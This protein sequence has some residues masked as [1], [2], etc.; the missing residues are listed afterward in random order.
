MNA[1]HS[2]LLG[3]ALVL[4]APGYAAAQSADE[5]C[6]ALKE[7][8]PA[9]K[10]GLPSGGATIESADVVAASPL[11]AAQLPFGPLPPYLAV[12]PAAPEYCKVLGAIAPL[13]PKAP[14]IRFQ[15]NLPSEWNGSS[16]QFG[17]GGFNGMLITGLGLPP[18]ALADSPSPLARGFV[19]YGTDSGHQ[20]PPVR[21]SRHLLS[22]MKR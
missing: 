21:R 10:I 16:V 15:V 11:T 19:T 1:R 18:L 2:I 20:S 14:P 7:T 12:V 9:A 17:G 5:H 13:D 8:I 6:A 3:A 4:L 22:M